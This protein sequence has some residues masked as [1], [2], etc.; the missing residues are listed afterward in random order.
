MCIYKIKDKIREVVMGSIMVIEIENLHQRSTPTN[1]GPPACPH[2]QERSNSTMS[3]LYMTTVVHFSIYFSKYYLYFLFHTIK[4]FK[5][6][7]IKKHKRTCMYIYSENDGKRDKGLYELMWSE[8]N[9]RS[10]MS[11]INDQSPT[12]PTIAFTLFFIKTH[13]RSF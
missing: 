9:L 2:I 3:I 6:K 1:R 13:K 11:V 10:K 5:I 4:L 8:F 7:K 12:T